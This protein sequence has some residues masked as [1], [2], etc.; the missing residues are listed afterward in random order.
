[1]CYWSKVLNTRVGGVVIAAPPCATWIFL[2]SSST[3]RSWSNPGGNSSKCVLAANILIRRL[4]YMLHGFALYTSFVWGEQRMLFVLSPFHLCCSDVLNIQL[5]LY[6]AV[7]R[8]VK[9]IIE[10]PQSSATCPKYLSIFRPMF[11][12]WLH[13][14][15][16]A[17]LLLGH[18]GPLGLASDE[19]V[20]TVVWL[21]EWG[22]KSRY[23]WQYAKTS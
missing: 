6:V 4:I 2:S 21:Q 14:G 15:P 11:D 9:I 22:L 13:L 23:S 17:L 5:R 12:L 8:G 16:L 1:M 18:W 7:K 3:S 20:S 10:Q 19:I